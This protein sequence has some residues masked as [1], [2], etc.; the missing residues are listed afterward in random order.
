MT[1][2]PFVRFNELRPEHVNRD[3]QIH[4]T[5]TDGQATIAEIISRAEV[6]ELGEIAFTEH[7]R[8]ESAYF[9]GFAAEVRESRKT[10][11]VR[12]YVGIE[13]KVEDE[14]GTLDA[15]SGV[16]AESEIVLGSVH[17][18]PTVDGKF[19]PAREFR[20]EEAAR[21]ELA[22]AMALLKNAPID[23]LSHPGGMCQAAFGEFPASYFEMLM[24][25]SLERGIAIE[26]NTSYT[27]RLD[28]FL[29]ICRQV[30]PIVSV[31]SDVH[32]LS[33]LATC[34]DALRQRGL[35]CQ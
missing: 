7:V 24:Q 21:R 22:L 34:R 33:D 26:I 15:S 9:Q 12:V 17:R 27:R 30:N 4:T 25:A 6:L 16:L 3:L 32:K 11:N 8:K 29:T 23:V 5:A 1:R 2:P 18:F 13:A 31:G 14:N 35:G 28:E 19:L 10:T 20:Y